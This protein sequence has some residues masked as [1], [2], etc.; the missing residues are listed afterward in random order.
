MN[1]QHAR[2]RLTEDAITDLHRLWKKDPQIVRDVFAKM[3]L[4]ERSPQAGQPLLGDLVPFRKLTVGNRH[5][6]IIW[7]HSVDE[8]HRP[9]LEIAE[10]WAIGA[11]S[12]SEI[13]AEMKSRTDKLKRHGNPNAKPLVEILESFGSRKGSVYATPEPP[14]PTALPD[15]LEQGLRAELHMSEEQI[16]G[17]TPSEAHQLMIAHWSESK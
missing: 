14:K 1:H 7:R 12:D 15:W 5:W 10:V 2:V 6:R 4:L 9:V 13:Y 8:D 3:I 16:S 17:L 11:R